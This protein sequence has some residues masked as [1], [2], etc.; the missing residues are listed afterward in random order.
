MGRH[1]RAEETQ[2]CRSLRDCDALRFVQRSTFGPR[3]GDVD[4]PTARGVDGWLDDQ[5]TMAHRRRTSIGGSVPNDRWIRQSRRP[6]GQAPWAAER[7]R[8]SVLG[9]SR[10]NRGTRRR[11][12][13]RDVHGVGLREHTRR[14][15]RWL[16]SRLGRTP[17]RDEWIGARPTTVRDPSGDRGRRSPRCRP[18]AHASHDLGLFDPETV[19][20]ER[21]GSGASTDRLR[22]ATRIRR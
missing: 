5:M 9:S 15:R 18:W 2:R 17:H 7:D 14:Q 8:R 13:G 1:E 16:R 22:P 21:I 11:R 12:A 20:Q 4:A 10:G 3:S 6:R 19:P